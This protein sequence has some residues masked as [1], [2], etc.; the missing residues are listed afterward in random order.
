M[1]SSFFPLRENKLLDRYISTSLVSLS[2][3][4]YDKMNYIEVKP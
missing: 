4:L 1:L 3:L 2:S